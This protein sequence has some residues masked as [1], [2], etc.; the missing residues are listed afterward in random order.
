MADFEDEGQKLDKG[1]NED[2]ALTDEGESKDLDDDITLEDLDKKQIPEAQNIKEQLINYLTNENV[3]NFLPSKKYA[4]QILII[5]LRRRY[6]KDIPSDAFKSF[7]SLKVLDLSDNAI[8]TL[9]P[10][11][12]NSLSSLERLNLSDNYLSVLEKSLFTKLTSLKKLNLATNSIYNYSVKKR[13][14]KWQKRKR[15]KRW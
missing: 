2:M 11:I 14:K 4:N 3:R 13:W 15:R 1:K 8:E 9:K 10:D 6:I 7:G 5:K 12:F